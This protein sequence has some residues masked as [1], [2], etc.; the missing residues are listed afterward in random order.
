MTLGIFLLS[1]ADGKTLVKR[2]N[3][4]LKSLM[5]YLN[6]VAAYL[7]Q[8]LPFRIPLY[9]DGKQSMLHPFL[10]E[11]LNQQCNWQQ[12]QQ[13]KEPLTTDM[14]DAMHWHIVTK[15]QH[16]VSSFLDWEFAAF[17]FC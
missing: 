17:D 12:P 16:D 13:K 9:Q 7:E 15:Y 11:V 1:V 10:A 4:C 14:L 5:A 6:E 3:Q 2:A 8:L